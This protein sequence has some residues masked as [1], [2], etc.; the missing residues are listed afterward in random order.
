MRVNEPITNRE[1][2]LPDNELIASRADTGGKITFVNAAFVKISGFAEDELI[3]APHNIIRHPSMP[4][5]AFSDLWKTIKSGR[6]WEGYV[7]NRCKNGD[8]YWVRANVTP[9]LENGEVKEYISIRFKPTQEQRQEHEALY[10]HVREGKAKGI[11]IED[12]RAVPTGKI[13]QIISALSS[14]TGRLYGSL[15]VSSLAII[16]V[17]L[18]GAFGAGAEVIGVSVV[19]GIVASAYFNT[20]VLK[21]ITGSLKRFEQHFDA[22]ARQDYT[23]EIPAE[24]A[25]EFYDLIIMLRTVK[26]K[27]AYADQERRENDRKSEIRRKTQSEMAEHIESDSKAVHRATQEISSAVEDQA[28]TAS[29]MSS[30]VAEITSTMEELSSSSSQV[31]EHSQSVVSLADRTWENSKAGSEAMQA[32]LDRMEEIRTDNQHSLKVIEEL[33]RKSKEISKIMQIIESV[34]DQTKLIAFNAALEASSAGEAGKRFSVVASEIRRLADS[35]TDS[36]GEIADKVGEIQDAISNLVVTAEKGAVRID[37]G[38]SESSKV[39]T[40]LTQLETA[41]HDSST[42][43]Q[44]ISLATQQQ[45]TASGQVVVALREIVGASSQT[46]ESITRISEV[47]RNLTGLSNQLETL[48]HRYQLRAPDKVDG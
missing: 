21:N 14:I 30:S 25:K 27:L 9:L 37:A 41:A 44:Q 31:A 38:M 3:G 24:S 5:E 12:G 34:A 33:G 32:M 6:P 39:A 11:R 18:L 40:M 10:T 16:V 7:K 42:A 26:A 28:A 29:E 23:H 47:A 45:R 46:A 22:I 19:A 13:Y 43:A 20:Q 48:V 35:V 15:G 17:G 1:V 2:E 36:A 8:H 4:K